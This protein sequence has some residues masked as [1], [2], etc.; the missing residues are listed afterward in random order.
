MIYFISLPFAIFQPFQTSASL[1]DCLFS[2]KD[3][4][5]LACKYVISSH[6]L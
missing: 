3:M 1:G 6:N 5:D 2:E 4:F